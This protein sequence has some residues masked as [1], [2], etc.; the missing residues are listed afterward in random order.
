MLRGKDS[1][2]N[3]YTYNPDYED[4]DIIVV[5]A[6][7]NDCGIE[8]I[9]SIEKEICSQFFDDNG[10]LLSLGK[11]DCKTIQGILAKRGE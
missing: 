1:K 6:G 2:N 5:S 3:N 7:T 11:V 9:D 4:F 8:E 10:D